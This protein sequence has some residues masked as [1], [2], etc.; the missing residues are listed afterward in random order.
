MSSMFELLLLVGY[1]VTLRLIA[2]LVVPRLLRPE[3]ANAPALANSASPASEHGA[4]AL[5]PAEAAAGQTWLDDTERSELRSVRF[6]SAFG[7]DHRFVR[8]VRTYRGTGSLGALPPRLAALLRELHPRGAVR[9]AEAMGLLFHDRP[10]AVDEALYFAI[11]D[12]ASERIVAF[13]DRRRGRS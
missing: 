7:I 5:R 2:G 12:P 10:L 11:V 1:I 4:V 6:V 9:G 3:E 13:V 8:D